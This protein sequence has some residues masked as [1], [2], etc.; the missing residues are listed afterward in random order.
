MLAPRQ[1]AQP[2]PKGGRV[3]LKRRRTPTGDELRKRIAEARAADTGVGVQCPKCWV[4]T[5][6]LRAKRIKFGA[7]QGPAG[8][9]LVENTPGLVHPD[10]MV[11]LHRGRGGSMLQYRCPVCGYTW[12]AESD[13]GAPTPNA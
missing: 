11:A 2:A 12:S 9:G 10:T 3:V 5:P 6:G 4:H 13:T 8:G 7:S 1:A